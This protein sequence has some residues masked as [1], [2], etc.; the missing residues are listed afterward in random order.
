[1]GKEDWGAGTTEV[2]ESGHIGAGMSRWKKHDGTSRCSH[3]FANIRKRI[4]HAQT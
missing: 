3:V 2:A 1:M 4:P